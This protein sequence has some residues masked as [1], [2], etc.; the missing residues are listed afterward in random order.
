MTVREKMAYIRGRR[1]MTKKQMAGYC[2]VSELLLSMVE[3]G[4]VTHPNLV[5]RIQV[6]YGLNNIEAEELLPVNRRPHG[7]DY[8]PD[9]FAPRDYEYMRLPNKE[10]K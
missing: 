6:A 1:D 9:R 10:V 8:E 7:G 4:H 3:A 2:G 5:R